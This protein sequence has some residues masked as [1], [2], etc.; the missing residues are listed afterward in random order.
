VI[1][2]FKESNSEEGNKVTGKQL[3]TPN[4]PNRLNGL[5]G[6]N[7]VNRVN[8]LFRCL[9]CLPVYVFTLFT[10]FR[11]QKKPPGRADTFLSQ[12]SDFNSKTSGLQSIVSSR[13]YGPY[14]LYVPVPPKGYCIYG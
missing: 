4:T 2:K 12:N 5:N 14:G 1:V 9:P 11:G 7:R 13:P 6:V 8:S 10:V 3:N